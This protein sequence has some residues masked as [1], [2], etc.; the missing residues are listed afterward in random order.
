M[1]KTPLCTQTL[2]KFGMELFLFTTK[3]DFREDIRFFV[4]VTA[5]HIDFAEKKVPGNTEY[6]S[7]SPI[8]IAALNCSIGLQE[9]LDEKLRC[10]ASSG[11]G[12]ATHYNKSPASH[13]HHT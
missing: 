10:R 4:C 8:I 5:P 12:A 11:T 9:I 2:S 7:I 6:L 1:Y 13:L 3:S